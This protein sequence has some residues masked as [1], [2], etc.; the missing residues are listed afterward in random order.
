MLTKM[1]KKKKILYILVLDLLKKEA[2]KAI[3]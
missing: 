1:M 2:K 3:A